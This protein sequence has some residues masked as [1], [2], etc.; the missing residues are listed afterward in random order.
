MPTGR[1]NKAV[2]VLL[3]ISAGCLVLEMLIGDT[4]LANV[5]LLLLAIA[6]ALL[7]ALLAVIDVIQ[8]RTAKSIAGVLLS[9]APVAYVILRFAVDSV[10]AGYGP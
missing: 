10:P 4:I 9:G 2:L 7:A 6:V 1:W 8:K 3:A 5:L